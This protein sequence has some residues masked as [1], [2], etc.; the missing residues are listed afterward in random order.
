V[1]K[2]VWHPASFPHS[3]FDRL[4]PGRDAY[5][6]YARV[7][8]LPRELACRDMVLFLG[9]IDDSDM[10]YVNG[11][12]VGA[13]GDFEA[14]GSAWN[15]DREYRV[16]A[17]VL[18]PGEN[19]VLVRVHDIW[20]L[21][22]IVGPPAIGLALAPKEATWSFS[23][24]PAELAQT[25]P[26]APQ[27]VPVPIPDTGFAGR[28]KVPPATGRYRLE[29]GLPAGLA[30]ALTV[31][32]TPGPILDL[33]PVFDAAAVRLNGNQIGRCGLF[34][35]DG[36]PSGA[37]PGT[38]GPHLQT[39]R[40]VRCFLPHRLLREGGNVLDVEVYWTGQFGGLPGTPM[41]LLPGQAGAA[42]A[43]FPDLARDLDLADVLV[44]SSDLGPAARLLKGVVTVTTIRLY[45]AIDGGNPAE[46]TGT[47]YVPRGS[48][49]TFEA[50]LLPHF[51]PWPDGGPE[52]TGAEPGEAVGTASAQFP[53]V[54]L[55]AGAPELV[56]ATCGGS[57][58]APV[59]VYDL[60]PIR[61]RFSELDPWQ[62]APEA[63]AIP[64]SCDLVY[65]RAAL[66]PPDIPPADLCLGWA[67]AQ[68]AI[69]NPCEAT[70]APAPA[71]L[72]GVEE[73]PVVGATAGMLS[74]SMRA[75][76]VSFG[77][78]QYRVCAL[79]PDGTPGAAGE[80]QDP[81]PVP[82]RVPVG[83]TVEFQAVAA[84]SR[85]PLP[86]EYL[87]WS[88]STGR[89]GNG[90]LFAD[91]FPAASVSNG[92]LRTVL[93]AYSGVSPTATAAAEFVA[94]G[95]GGM[96][97]ATGAS[98]GTWAAVDRVLCVAVGEPFRL[99]ALATPAGPWPDAVPAW[100]LSG[101]ST[102]GGSASDPVVTD[103]SQT[104]ERTLHYTSE[105]VPAWNPLSW[106]RCQAAC[107]TSA[108]TAHIAVVSGLT[109]LPSWPSVWPGAPYPSASTKILAWIRTRTW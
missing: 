38:S 31:P 5:G 65:V 57:G 46:I 87:S 41:V 47:L 52:W 82:A 68:A 97:W 94:C 102:V 3:D 107:G 89:T 43:A 13:M 106:A 36:Q 37:D 39:A 85:V 1:P 48:T 53:D 70:F 108:A 16:P 101:P 61:Y 44:Q 18:V 67:G 93:V 60:G 21:G 81:T 76:R 7:L 2:P 91:V 100:W 86:G 84:A 32:G 6:V 90:Q 71:T 26:P 80:W 34:A 29:F 73:W 83:C 58:E 24:A 11:R 95:V 77:G 8:D 75:G 63:L 54:S 17:D 103:D 42:D 104:D 23:A 88:S 35:D 33:G 15:A 27:W 79:N 72:A 49:V 10:A 55:S 64:E 74:R 99:R 69:L 19:V 92:D 98:G 22:G 78:I 51:S 96:E 50:D 30:R 12:P 45:A 66:L 56:V 59:V 25:G 9:V 4:Y 14:K 62:D 105:S 20:G 109:L 28:L 40:R